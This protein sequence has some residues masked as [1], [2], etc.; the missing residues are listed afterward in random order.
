M[1][2]ALGFGVTRLHRE[3]VMGIGLGGLA[4]PG[5]WRHLDGEEEQIVARAVALAG[6]ASDGA[7]QP[8]RADRPAAARAG[9]RRA[10]NR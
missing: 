4:S 1:C 5:E 7:G 2:E 3:Q 8:A 6:S 10:R 9:G